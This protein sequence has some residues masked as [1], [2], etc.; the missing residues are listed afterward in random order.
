LG[1]QYPPVLEP[2]GDIP[3]IVYGKE[4]ELK[5]QEL[6]WVG[7]DKKRDESRL[8]TP[9]FSGTILINARAL[10]Q[11]PFWDSPD[12]RRTPPTA[13]FGNLFVFRGTFNCG[14]LFAS[15]LYYEALSRIYIEKPA[16]EAAEQ[17]VRQSISLDPSPFFVHIRLGNLCL[18]RGSREDAL[19]AYS[20]AL[21]YA[22]ADSELRRSIRE[23]IKRVSVDPLDKIPEL[24]SPQTE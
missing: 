14:G 9:N 8:S 18:K 12:L 17:L 15:N 19:R 6:D 4:V 11:S 2:A 1:L 21:Q 22:P 10:N 3:L 20:D 13:R 16:L 7:H 23:Q 24:R 5:A